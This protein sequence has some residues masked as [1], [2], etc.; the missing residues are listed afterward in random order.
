MFEVKDAMKSMN[1]ML[2]QLEKEKHLIEAKI[3][4]MILN[5]IE[6]KKKYELIYNIKGVAMMTFAVIIAETNGFASFENVRQLTSYAGYDIVEN[7]SGSHSGKTRISKKGNTHL[8]RILHLPALNIVKY[9]PSFSA[10]YERIYHKTGIK[11]KAYVAVQRKL[12]CLIYTLWKK[13]EVFNPSKNGKL[14]V[15]N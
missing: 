3:K 2:K 13:N 6:L 10:F 11:M 4:E 9:E 5:D 14:E 12:L 1:K 8:R 7:Q 15:Q